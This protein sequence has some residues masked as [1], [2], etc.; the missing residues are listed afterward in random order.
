MGRGT[1][2][3][4]TQ[5]EGVRRGG[6]RGGMS[7]ARVLGDSTNHIQR[8]EVGQVMLLCSITPYP[9]TVISLW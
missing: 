5:G 4:V 9:T 3:R 6:P 2:G 8:G 7:Q 1:R